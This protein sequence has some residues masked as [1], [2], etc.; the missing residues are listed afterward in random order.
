MS[1]TNNYPLF[2]ADQVLK[3]E[4]LNELFDYL[5]QDHRLTRRCFL[6]MGIVCGLDIHWSQNTLFISSGLASTSEGYKISLE[7]SQF[8]HYRSYSLPEDFQPNDDTEND[9]KPVYGSLEFKRL[10]SFKDKKSSD[11]TISSLG[12]E[13]NRWAVMLF[14]ERLETDLK[15]CTTTDCDDK[16]KKVI[17][18]V[19]PM[20]VSISDYDDAFGMLYGKYET[21]KLPTVKLKRFN[22]PYKKFSSPSSVIS[23]FYRICDNDVLNQLSLAYKKAAIKV[24][25]IFH[26]SENIKF[27][28]MFT[29]LIE[30]RNNIKNTKPIFSQ[31]YYDHID[32]LIKAYDELRIKLTT[33]YSSCCP[34]E[35]IFP[36]HVLL[37]ILGQKSQGNSIAL[38]HY[39]MHSPLF[40]KQ[41]LHEEEINSLLNRMY[42]LLN[43]F[44]LLDSKKLKNQVIITPS[45]I[46]KDDLSDRAIPYYYSIENV[47][48][49]WNYQKT[50]R[51]EKTKNLS[52]FAHQYSTD[53]T[54]VHPLKYDLE[55]NNFLRIEGHIGQSYKEMLKNLVSQKRKNNLP[56]DVLALNIYPSKTSKLNAQVKCYFSDLESMYKVL[57]AEFLCKLKIVICPLANKTFQDQNIVGG[58]DI[59]AGLVS[60]EAKKTVLT[61]DFKEKEKMIINEKY[62][63]SAYYA[64]ANYFEVA[65]FIEEVQRKKKYTAGSFLSRFCKPTKG[66]I[67]Y[68]YLESLKGKGYWA[69]DVQSFSFDERF[70]FIQ[71]IMAFLK[72]IDE[73]LQDTLLYS[74]SD[75]P[76]EKFSLDYGQMTSIAKKAV[77]MQGDAN[78]VLTIEDYESLGRLNELLTLCLDT[79]VRELYVEYSN[80]VK[81]ISLQ[82]LFSNYAQNNGGLEHKAGVPM[83]GTF[84][85]LYADSGKEDRAQ[86]LQIE[87]KDSIAVED[88][89]F[90]QNFSAHYA[91]DQ[92]KA[93]LKKGKKNY[94]ED[95]YRQI[96][97][98]LELI[99]GNTQ[100]TP[101]VIRIPEG[102]VFADFYVPYLCCSECTPISYMMDANPPQEEEV[103]PTL[104]V[105]PLAFCQGS[106][107]LV[108]LT[109]TPEGGKF[110]LN[111][112][113]ITPTKNSQGN[114]EIS[115]DEFQIGVNT[116]R[117]ILDSG[118]SVEETTTKHPLPNANFSFNNSPSNR[119]IVQFNSED[120][121]P[122]NTHLWDFGDGSTK[123]N[124]LANPV[125]TYSSTTGKSEYIV[126]HTIKSK[127]GC[128][129]LETKT[130]SLKGQDMVIKETRFFCHSDKIQWET[131]ENFV[132]KD[133]AEM[134]DTFNKYGLSIDSKT[135]LLKY[136][137][138]KP[139]S[140][141]NFTITYSY[142]ENGITITKEVFTTILFADTSFNMRL[143]KSALADSF[144]ILKPKFIDVKESV[145]WFVK[146]DGETQPSIQS[147]EIELKFPSR[148]LSYKKMEITLIVHEKELDKCSSSKIIQL[149]TETITFDHI[150]SSQ[151]GID[152]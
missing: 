115:Q 59:K 134:K 62:Q 6:G 92:V 53:D 87:G 137:S 122:E 124:T 131:K 139:I 74:I 135:F 36:L 104:N 48:A 17:F 37:G 24:Q 30:R 23:E 146:L 77:K 125:H 18:N 148:K 3:A 90:T 12:A 81:S 10:I 95:Q 49:H 102:A 117:Y 15:N 68:Y 70:A 111:K 116:I 34:P 109:V 42:S 75:L 52:Y 76:I 106:I 147:K 40:S 129:N 82:K 151:T 108:V 79:R 88:Q 149:P 46:G 29:I 21:L 56:I 43:E 33:L 25:N 110:E 22:V 118:N 66:S 47:L 60:D 7:A 57:L 78:D 27:D 67:G 45:H 39:F 13:M 8:T 145:E 96:E 127:T 61:G 55:K 71:L 136:S 35:N 133:D 44:Q 16:G 128:D 41:E 152:F 150:A 113:S 138:S 112:K 58:I 54:I 143:E 83:G 28:S 140:D 4:H 126:T 63:Y 5:D 107:D 142:T 72:E 31:Y 120:T 93:I 114:Y 26:S 80:R 19:V 51:G 2:A 50:Y 1:T 85:L 132:I 98:Y 144:W 38:R 86:K 64:V 89:I 103:M 65:Q 105:K 94:S 32:D 130:V 9:Y 101:D 119:F 91:V 141:I 123:D 84:I 20:L 11:K 97:E 99:Q 121:T 73:V 69:N 100:E 14:L